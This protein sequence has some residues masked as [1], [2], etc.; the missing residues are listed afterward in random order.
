[1]LASSNMKSH[2][3]AVCPDPLFIRNEACQGIQRFK[4]RRE[5]SINAITAVVE[6]AGIS[7][8]LAL[9]GFLAG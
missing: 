1:M 4:G 6:D 5:E 3:L 2:A 8:V 7:L 9:P